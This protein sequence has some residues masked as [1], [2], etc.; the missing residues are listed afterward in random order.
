M[1]LLE[2]LCNAPGTSGNENAIRALIVKEIKP[3]VDK[4]Y[5][6]KIG[7]LIAAKKGRKPRIM[8]A[9]HM[10]EI[11]LMVKSIDKSGKIFISLVGGIEPMTLI[12]E[13]VGVRTPKGHINGI[14]S[15]VEMSTG[16]EIKKAPHLEDI[17]VD[18]GLSK[19]EL[20]KIGITVGSY[21]FLKQHLTFMGNKDFFYGK[22][23]DDRIGCY[24]LI[25]LAKQLKKSKLETYFVFTAQE[26]IGLYG[27]T[28]S[29]YHIV[30]DWAIVVDVTSAN[31]SADNATKCV[32]KGPYITVKDADI[33]GSPLLNAHIR[34]IAKKNRVPLQFEVSDFGSS[35]AL[36]IS[37]SREGVLS[38]V[39]GVVIRNIHTSV[40]VA[41]KKDI[42]FV[43]KL[44][45]AVLQSP[46]EIHYKRV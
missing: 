39:V 29:A 15:T 34:K 26:E 5:V 19:S 13:R 37:V 38:T 8:L 45:V 20:L 17:F 24:I 1:D 4:I 22:A 27:A 16:D 40:S 3:F 33:I 6:D 41:S 14:I 12:G 25:Q 23:L 21:I 28:T 7:N 11:G 35:D 43:I 18:V 42:D 10:D 31:D 30:P 44:L 46:P 36:A 2:R 9:A 32:G